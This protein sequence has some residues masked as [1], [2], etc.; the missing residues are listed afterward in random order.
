[1]RAGGSGEKKPSFNVFFRGPNSAV[2]MRTMVA[3]SSMAT[4]RSCDMPIDRCCKSV[5]LRQ[6][7]QPREI[8]A[9][10]L[11]VVGPGRHGHQPQQPQMRAAANGFHQRRHFSGA[12]PAL[13]SSADSFTSII[14]SSVL[15]L[16]IQA[17]RQLRRIHGLDHVENLGGILRFVGLQMADQM[18]SRAG[19]IRLARRAWLRTPARSSRRIRG[20]PSRRLLESA[21][22]G[23]FLVTASKVMSSRLRPAR[24]AAFAIRVSTCS[25]FSLSTG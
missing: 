21:T 6:R 25:S 12:A 18:E 3:P 23:N 22:A 4:S 20:V 11:G 1:M 10:R 16:R 14:T 19:A 8:R 13:A 24:A 5:R 9:R 7:A 17:P 15:L 2:P